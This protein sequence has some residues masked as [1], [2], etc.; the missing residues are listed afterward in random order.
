MPRRLPV[1]MVAFCSAAIA[2]GYKAQVEKIEKSIP[3]DF[4]FE[5]EP[6]KWYGYV[7]TITPEHDAKSHVLTLQKE[8]THGTSVGLLFRVRNRVEPKPLGERPPSAWPMAIR[9]KF[10]KIEDWR[11][12]NQLTLWV[13]MEGVRRQQFGFAL[14]PKDKVFAGGRWNQMGAMRSIK[15]KQWT[16]FALRLD[17]HEK[18]KRTDLQQVKIYTQRFGVEPGSRSDHVSFYLDDFRLNKVVE[19]KWQGW[20]P[21][22]LVIVVNQVGYPRFMPKRGIVNATSAQPGD[23]FHVT[24]LRT[25]KIA[26]EGKLN[27]AASGRCEYL[28][29]DF[30]ALDAPGEYRARSGKLIS[31]A[32]RVDEDPYAFL[33]PLQLDWLAGSRCGCATAFHGPCHFD[34][35]M[36]QGKRYPCPGGYHDACDLRRFMQNPSIVAGVCANALEET[37]LSPALEQRLVEEAL[38]A[39]DSHYKCLKHLGFIPHAVSENAK[40]PNANIWSDNVVGTADDRHV[41]DP[42]PRPTDV[43]LE[44][45]K[46]AAQLAYLLKQ[47]AHPRA[48]EILDRALW[49]WRIFQNPDYW[50]KHDIPAWQSLDSN[51]VS[52]GLQ[53]QIGL[54]LYLATG[55][56]RFKTYAAEN[57]TKLTTK[58]QT[59]FYRDAPVTGNFVRGFGYHR[60]IWQASRAT[61]ALADLC[62]HL[63]DHPDFMKW[64]FALK[65]NAEFYAK[66]SAKLQEPYGLGILNMR[67]HTLGDKVRWIS[68][69]GTCTESNLNQAYGRLRAARVLGDVEVERIA[70]KQLGWGLGENPFA[71]SALYETGEDFIEDPAAYAGL[72]RGTPMPGVAYLPKGKTRSSDTPMFTRD[73]Y[74]TGYASSREVWVPLPSRYLQLTAALSS[75]ALMSG[76]VRSGHKPWRGAVT[77]E[78]PNGQTAATS[79]ADEKGEFGPLRLRGG[80]EYKLRLGPIERRLR[81]VSGQNLQL[82]VDLSR[83]WQ[84]EAAAPARIVHGEAAEVSLRMKSASH[85]RQS[86]RFKAMGWNLDFDRSER[87]FS[88]PA[89]GEAR[90]TWRVRGVEADKPFVAVFVPDGKWQ[91]RVEVCGEVR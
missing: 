45:L 37:G 16:K 22:P 65:I 12:F 11:E 59:T 26:F 48:G 9:Y 55:Q 75:P 82:D 38:W 36:Y 31:A 46:A 73:N 35:L 13:W 30:S 23:V 69:G 47:R 56:E 29:A 61:A 58:Q 76:R 34:D 53:S 7:A 84:A 24:G 39:H 70:V 79:S 49:Q 2:Q 44:S 4:L 17:C 5:Q 83:A 41:S 27:A 14:V 88:L 51:W 87:E 62:E 32:F 18:D 86:V 52:L 20:E 25:G 72:T 33:L 54:Y 66:P 8:R 81:V 57:G 68:A 21:D 85:T 71:I 15:E 91:R 80:I 6:E 28:V 43:H 10:P 1:A 89:K 64:Y 90:A 40:S 19:R 78:Y 42:R 74:A 67:G 60:T 3:I 77:V 50:K 63:P